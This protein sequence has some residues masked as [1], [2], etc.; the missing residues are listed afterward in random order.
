MSTPSTVA[1]SSWVAPFRCRVA[2]RMCVVRSSENR[3]LV[4]TTCPEH[5]SAGRLATIGGDC[6]GGVVTGDG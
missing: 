6:G 1:F 4:V 2:H 3:D 5:L